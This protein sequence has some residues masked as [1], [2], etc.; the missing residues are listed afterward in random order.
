MQCTLCMLYVWLCIVLLSSCKAFL[1]CIKSEGLDFKSSYRHDH[2]RLYLEYLYAQSCC[3]FK[4]LFK[5]TQHPMQKDLVIGSKTIHDLYLLYIIDS[6]NTSTHKAIP[7]VIFSIDVLKPQLMER[8]HLRYI[9][10]EGHCE[11]LLVQI[12]ELQVHNR[13]LLQSVFNVYTKSVP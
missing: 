5:N 8:F 1:Y 12:W 6:R 3:V 9:C 10:M 2:L 7:F 13:C 11:N 4:D